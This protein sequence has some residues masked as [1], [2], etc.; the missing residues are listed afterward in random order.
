MMASTMPE[1]AL[2]S[3]SPVR[4]WSSPGHPRGTGDTHRPH[5][6]TRLALLMPA[7]SNPACNSS[8]VALFDDSFAA[9]SALR[10]PDTATSGESAVAASPDDRLTLPD[11][12]AGGDVGSTYG[13]AVGACSV[14]SC[15]VGVLSESQAPKARQSTNKAA[16][17]SD[18]ICIVVTQPSWRPLRSFML[19]SRRSLAYT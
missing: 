5:A 14:S 11:A 15:C 6:P 17:A 2:C 16:T 9:G 8:V 10:V 19:D 4:S 7:A 13:T 1:S 12:W 18:F 3:A